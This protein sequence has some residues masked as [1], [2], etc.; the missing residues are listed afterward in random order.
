MNKREIHLDV[1]RI[2]ACLAV[3][4]FHFNVYLLY[5]NSET[6]R[7]GEISYLNQT[8]GDIAI[9][10]FIILSGFSL[11]VSQ[12]HDKTNLKYIDFYKRRFLGIFPSFWIAY[13]VVAIT[14]L[15][16]GQPFGDGQ[17]WKFLLTI[18]GLDGFFLY[19]MQSYYLV[20]EWYTGYMLITYLMYPFLKNFFDKKPL[21]CW[22]VILVVFVSLNDV[23]NEI[24]D[25]YI[26]CNPIMRLPEIL[27]GVTFATYI[28]GH[29]SKEIIL[30]TISLLIVLLSSYL[31][32][33]LPSQIYM[34]MIGV[35]IFSII[36]LILSFFRFNEFISNFIIK[37][38]GLT[39]LAFLF[40]HQIIYAVFRVFD[41]K[42]LDFQQKIALY[43]FCV[44]ASFYLAKEVSPLVSKFS[45]FLKSRIF[46]NP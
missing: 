2:V 36:S 29:R 31:H 32:D 14:F 44:L 11:T 9:S 7:I 45:Y 35:S 30:A 37:I 46:K 25:V 6:Q 34:F 33:F 39:F 3:I 24:F 40:H 28:N 15:L 17:W 23:Y 41:Y 38:S 4:L 12:G 19:R 20:G 22:I 26:N 42:T 21:Y 13:V 1:I 8:V 5:A 27:F 16:V 10:L 43:V 18:I